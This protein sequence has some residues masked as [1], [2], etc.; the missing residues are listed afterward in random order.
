MD[1]SDRLNYA[2]QRALMDYRAKPIYVSIDDAW[3]TPGWS[4]NPHRRHLVFHDVCGEGP[5]VV[6]IAEGL[7]AHILSKSAH[8]GR[9]YIGAIPEDFRQRAWPIRCVIVDVLLDAAK[10][11]DD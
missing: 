11:A 10:I 1:L 9:G 2:V 7:T 6:D 5:A 3:R 4:Y 8:L